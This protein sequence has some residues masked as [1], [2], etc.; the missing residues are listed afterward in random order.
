MSTA[1]LNPQ[2]PFFTLSEAHRQYRQAFRAFVD[3]EIRPIANEMDREEAFAES[4]IQRMAQE[5][6]LGATIDTAYGGKGWDQ[7]TFGLMNEEI[8]RGCSSA[9]SLVTVHLALV[10]ETIQRWGTPEQKEEWLPQLAT[11]KKI[12]CFGLSEAAAGSDAANIQSQYKEEGD[13]FVLNGSKKW[14]TFGARADVVLFMARN[15]KGMS[16]FLVDTQAE[17]VEVV[18]MF[19]M[20][21]TRASMVAELK[22]NNVKVPATRLLGRKGLGMAQIVNNALDNGRFSVGLGTLGI[23]RACLED[24]I[25]YVKE[26]NAFGKAIKDHQLVQRKITNML[27]EVRGATLMSYQA[28]SMRAM[29]HPR[30]IMHTTMA[31]YN[32]AL[33][34][35]RAATEAVQIF[36]A[37][38]CHDSTH[39][40]RYFRDAKIM[41]IIEGTNEI[42]QVVIAEEGIRNPDTFLDW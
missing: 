13:Y 24:S 1:T 40:N 39:V 6:F 33:V 31:K 12:A 26:R 7:I 32:T 25:A 28:A 4:L 37:L 2:A 27:T 30:S 19:G 14:T 29:K 35:N 21:G 36:G 38:G 9:R 22:L 18:P 16:A 20:L 23:A 34:A 3:A 17:G 42:Q 5:G 10:A 15:E 41:E 11:G 8:G